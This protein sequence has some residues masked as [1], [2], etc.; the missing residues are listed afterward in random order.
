MARRC[1][2]FDRDSKRDILW[3]NDNGTLAVWL[4]NGTDAAAIGPPIPNPGPICHAKEAEDTNGDGV[5]DILWQNDD[6]TP[7]VWLM[8]GM[9]VAAFGPALPDPSPSW[10][11]I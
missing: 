9:D 3:Q 7:G 2:D 4:M 6:G 11:V 1:G 10:H 5:A 8:N